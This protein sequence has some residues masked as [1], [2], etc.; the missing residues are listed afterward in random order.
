MVDNHTLPVRSDIA[1]EDQWDLTPLFKND[2]QWEA[3]FASLSQQISHYKD[4]KDQL[5]AS[6]RQ[7]ADVLNFH[8]KVSRDLENIFTYAHLKSDQD[9]SDSRSLGMLER[10]TGLMTRFFE[11]SSFISPTVQAIDAE[12]MDAFMASTDLAEYHFFLRK[13][14]RNAPHTLDE[15]AETILAMSSEIAQAPSAIFGQ[16]DNADLT[17][18]TIPNE[19]GD[20]VT[21]SHGNFIT[22]LMKPSRDLREKAFHQYYK[23]YDG[24]K[25]GIASA[26]AHSV[27]KDVF[28]ARV[29]RYSSCRAAALFADDV[30]ESVYD[31]LVAT[32][33][34]NLSPLFRYLNHRRETLGV[35]ELHFYDTYVP[36]VSEIEFKCT[37]E[38]AVEIVVAA[39][40]PLGEAYTIVLRQ[41]LLGGWVDRYENK[42]KRSGAYSSGSYDSPPYILMNFR[43]ND[44]NSLYTLI[45]EAGHSMHSYFSKKNQPYVD[46]DYTIFAAEVASTFNE[47]LLSRHLL[48]THQNDVGMTSYILN[49]EID[50]IR[51]TFFRQ[52]MFAEFETL[53]HAAAENHKPLTVDDLTGIYRQLLETYFG[54]SM[55]IDKELDLECLRIPHFYRAFYVYKYATGIAAAITL[56]DKVLNGAAADRDAYLGFLSLGGSKFPLDALKSA[57]ADMASPEPILKTTAYFEKL[58][59]QFILKG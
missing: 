46:Y 38:E 2:D 13:I 37:Y 16:L 43:K 36:L 17:F 26:L 52:T 53:T 23:T 51:A 31:N 54:G 19:N 24:H 27:K 41:G 45:H 22:F 9:K 59:D 15:N 28:Y 50:N 56:A 20:T 21:L 11:A 1:A 30:P 33:K 32:V 57:G 58:V 35:D 5:G 39:L 34:A 40:A 14:I 6:A 10:A 42:G 25:Y 8:M 7:M 29:R 44:I 18:G 12:R 55:V 47:M 3:L 48:A 4:L 49:R